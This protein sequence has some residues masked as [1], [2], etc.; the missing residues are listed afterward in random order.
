M[1][2]TEKVMQIALSLVDGIGSAKAEKLFSTFSSAS[3]ILSQDSSTISRYADVSPEYAE[4]L[5]AQFPDAIKAANQEY[6]YTL[7]KDIQ[8]IFFTDDAYPERM[9]QC[10]GFPLVIY[11]KGDADFNTKKYVSIVGTRR[12]TEHGKRLCTKFVEDLAS[13]SKDIVIISGL[14]FGIDITA[15]KAAIESGLKTYGVVAGGFEHFYPAE[16]LATAR[17]MAAGNGGVITEMVKDILPKPE[18]FARRNRIIAAMA[19]ATVVVESSIKGGSLIT[20]EQAISYGR[21]LYAFPGKVGDRLSEGC[22]NYIKYNKAGLIENADD[23]LYF[24]GWQANGHG[25]N[26]ILD[27]NNLSSEEQLVFRL[28]EDNKTL[29]RD[30]LELTL[31]SKIDL[32]GTLFNMEI[33][34]IIESLPGN[35]YTLC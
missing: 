8:P 25:K 14:A 2:D 16:H 28:L 27:Y 34:G 12:A 22:N 15:H 26:I 24:M 9:R 32:P 10:P 35:F 19:D 33:K 31:G 11:L 6:E 7:R 30:T 4:K 18:N 29:H 3:E 5:T 1:Q 23:F 20:A 21:D 13:Y 17:T